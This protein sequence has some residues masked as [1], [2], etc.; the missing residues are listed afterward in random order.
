MAGLAYEA[1]S[2]RG[3]TRSGHNLYGKGFFWRAR[4]FAFGCGNPASRFGSACYVTCYFSFG[5]G[6]GILA[7]TWNGVTPVR[8]MTMGCPQQGQTLR[9]SRFDPIEFDPRL[10]LEMDIE[11]LQVVETELGS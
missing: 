3:G 1:A 2:G 9:L 11:K 4:R 8:T 5:G 10:L 7:A 6:V